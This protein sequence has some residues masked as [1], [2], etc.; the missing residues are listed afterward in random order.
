MKN[1]ICFIRSFF[2]FIRLFKPKNVDVVFYYPQHFNKSKSGNI[3]LFN[4]LIASCEIH[5]V[6]YCL[7][8]EPDFQVKSPRNK[9]AVPFDFV[10]FLILVLRKLSFNKKDET[11]N[12]QEQRIGAI[13]KSTIFRKFNFTNY[14]VLSQSMLGVFRSI[15]PDAKLFDLQHGIIYANKESYINKNAV[16]KSLLENDVSVLLFG[17]G[18]KKILSNQSSY[19]INKAI[20]LGY[21]N[22]Q[23]N[24]KSHN[25]NILVTLQFTR[26]LSKQINN[27]IFKELEDIFKT[28]EDSDWKFYLKNHPRFNN[29]VPIENLLKYK[30]VYTAPSL[31]DDCFKLCNFHLTSYSTTAFEAAL[32]GIPTYFLKENGGH[33]YFQ[34]EYSYPLSFNTL[35]DMMGLEPIAIEKL[36]NWYKQYYS[37]YSEATFINVLK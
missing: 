34:S 15:N 11:F 25:K 26:D 19:F 28:Y 2:F 35:D 23:S 8:E 6:S 30:N 18:F 3:P 24:Q 21:E 29:E 13:L 10:W 27:L 16:A 17:D 22:V 33:Q 12:R 32:L 4:H 5:G 14:I 37:P 36:K 20:V 31:L 9:N 1:V 7:F